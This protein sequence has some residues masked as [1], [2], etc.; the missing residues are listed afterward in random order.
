MSA[1]DLVLRGGRV[2]TPAGP[3]EGDVAVSGGR[4]LAVTS[5]EAA[6]RA[7]ETLDVRGM[8]VLPG[9][10][11]TH[12]HHREPGFTH[13]EDITSA[14]RAAAAGG[15]TTSVGMPNVEPPT[16]T[17]ERYRAVL[18]LYGRKAVVDFNHNPSPTVLDEVPALAREGALGF[19]VWMLADTKR[20]YPHMP[21][22]AVHDHGHLLEIAETV[23][24]TGRPLMIH[25]H[26]QDLMRTIEQRSW[27][28]G[29]TDHRAYARAF[30]SYG[31]IVWD[32]AAAWCIR[33]QEATGVRLHMLHVKTGRLAQ[34]VRDAK[35]RG[36]RVTAELNPI[37]V[38]AAH[39]WANVERLGPY[40]LSTWTGPDQSEHLWE[41]LR[42]GTIDVIGTDHAPHTREEKEIGWKDMWKAGGGA[43]AIQ[44]YIPLFLTAVSE[45]RLTLE[46]LA[47]L[48]SAGPA[49]VF[50]LYPR[51]GAILEGSDADLAVVDPEREG[52]I[53]AADMHSKCGWSAFAGMRVRGAVVHTIVRGAPVL[54]DGVVVGRPGWGRQA[55]PA[56][57][58]VSA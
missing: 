56:A 42:D 12:T 25:P 18:A 57:E 41:A 49:R 4:I 39:D 3:V 45:G 2:V 36:Q 51:K 21:G 40:V 54:R 34:L 46:R 48:A 7:R 24:R 43:P 58:T 29:E 22:T 55:I 35:A 47:E 31:G 11:D 53:R 32:G 8:V 19:K 14:T 15:V 16:N 27:A 10:I 26:D 44:E 1:A 23:A 20:A 17:V 50:G 37:A 9:A 6:P 38:F 13:K 52:A 33:L 28:R 30:A 5:G